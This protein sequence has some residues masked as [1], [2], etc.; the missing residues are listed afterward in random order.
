[1]GAMNNRSHLPS[2]AAA[3]WPGLVVSLIAA[4]AAP[5]A[6]ARHSH[7]HADA[8]RSASVAGQFDYYLLALSW[9]PTYCLTHSDDQAQ[10]GSRGYGFVLHGLW[11]QYTDGGYPE[12]CGAEAPLSAAARRVGESLYPSPKLVSHEWDRHGRCSGLDALGYFHTAD[13]ALA[14]V[15][16]PS[17]LQTPRQSLALS[18]AQI[19]AAFRSANPRLAADGIAIVC[20]RKELS[21]VRVCL[22]PALQWRS[23]G[24]GE[25][26]SC[27]AGALQIP[28]SR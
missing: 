3:L 21:E 10:C 8:A 12:Y 26:D 27:P 1:M 28:A 20:A 19:R 25:R 2:P 23:C 13:R 16:V 9:S 7:R 14:V 18:A 24:R 11:P 17:A 5:P 22:D 4:L 15:Q 6:L